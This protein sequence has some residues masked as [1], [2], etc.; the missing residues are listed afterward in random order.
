V[1]GVARL[2]RRWLQTPVA[3]RERMRVA[4][5]RCFERRFEISRATDSLLS[6]LS[7]SGRQS[8]AGA[9]SIVAG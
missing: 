1:L 7:R 5:R 9:Q 2:L 8:F 3:D 6:V 4:A